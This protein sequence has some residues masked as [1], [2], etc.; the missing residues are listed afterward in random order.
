[1]ECSIKAIFTGIDYGDK[2]GDLKDLKGVSYANIEKIVLALTAKESLSKYK[3]E[4]CVVFTDS[5]KT[6]EGIKKKLPSKK[7]ILLALNDLVMSAKQG[8]ALLFYFCGHGRCSYGGESGSLLTLNDGMNGLDPIHTQELDEVFE[9]LSVDVSVSCLINTST[10]ES[11]FRY[12]PKTTT[13]AVLSSCGPLC[14]LVVTKG[15]RIRD[16]FA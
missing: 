6:I 13:G 15:F 16:F 14:P 8:E 9:R 2:I 12:H 3:K 1:M 5:D 10:T 11:V 7:N 4:E